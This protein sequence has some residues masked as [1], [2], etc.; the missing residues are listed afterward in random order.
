MLTQLDPEA[1]GFIISYDI[2][3]NHVLIH[4]IDVSGEGVLIAAGNHP[5]VDFYSR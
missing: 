1:R 3:D 4:N 5:P 2:E